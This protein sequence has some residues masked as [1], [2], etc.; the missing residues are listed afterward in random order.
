MDEKYTYPRFFLCNVRCTTCNKTL[1]HLQETLETE[2]LNIDPSE[3]I[4]GNSNPEEKSNIAQVLDKMGVN[5]LCCRNTMMNMTP[6]VVVKK[7]NPVHS[8]VKKQQ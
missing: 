4:H 6:F 7:T 8:V 1:A 3:F 2:I 5:R